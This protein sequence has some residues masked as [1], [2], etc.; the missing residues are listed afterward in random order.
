M[1]DARRVRPHVGQ[2]DVKS[3]KLAAQLRGR[4]GEDVAD[5]DAAVRHADVDGFAVQTDQRRAAPGPAGH[6]L[7]PRSG[8]TAQIEDTQ[9]V[10]SRRKQV[11]TLVDFEKLVDRAGNEAFA[12]RPLVEVIVATGPIAE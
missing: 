12:S 8:T 6:V 7:Q 5:D 1:A 10:P 4:D 9:A 3:R 2:H 11:V